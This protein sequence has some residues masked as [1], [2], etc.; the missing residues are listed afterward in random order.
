V[1]ENPA[2]PS[3]LDLWQKLHSLR[4]VAVEVSGKPLFRLGQPCRGIYLVEAGDVTLRMCSAPDGNH[5]LEVVGPGTVLGLSESMTGATYRLTAE[6]REG[7]RISYIERASFLDLVHNDHQF[8]LQIVRALSE[9]LHGLYHLCRC[10]G[11]EAECSE[12]DASRI[13]N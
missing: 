11:L 12:E 10:L 2:N 6:A 1:T 8:C 13:V 4:S 7:A 3:R 9:D 5:T